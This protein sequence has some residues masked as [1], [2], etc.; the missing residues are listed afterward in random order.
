MDVK[1]HREKGHEFF[2]SLNDLFNLLTS[3]MIFTASV[4]KEAVGR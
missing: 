3:F 2:L 1:E 4:S